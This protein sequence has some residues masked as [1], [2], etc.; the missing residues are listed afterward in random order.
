M[1]NWDAIGAVG[2]IMGAAAVVI[3]LLYLGVQIRSQTRQARFAAAHDI[4]LGFR[5]AMDHFSGPHVSQIYIKGLSGID[6]L[7]DFE[8]F[9][10]LLGSLKMLRVW[11]EAFYLHQEG[12]LHGKH[13]AGVNRQCMSYMKVPT[14][15][16]TW[17]IRAQFFGEEFR[18]MVEESEAVDYK[19]RIRE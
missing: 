7:E 11:E 15:K 3:S 1:M 16:H 12:Q 17:E 10:L 5:E 18:E 13:W 2:E 4:S 14:F 6:D 8:L 19:L 9:Q